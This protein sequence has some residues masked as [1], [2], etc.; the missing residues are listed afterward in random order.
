[1]Q[2]QMLTRR[3]EPAPAE[4][5]GQDAALVFAGASDEASA[6]RLQGVL[7]VLLRK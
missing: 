7:K 1:M 4:T 3:N 5:W 6:R 2:L